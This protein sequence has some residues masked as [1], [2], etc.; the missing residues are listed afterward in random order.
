L[1]HHRQCHDHLHDTALDHDSTFEIKQL[2]PDFRERSRRRKK[3]MAA[4]L[5]RSFILPYSCLSRFGRYRALPVIY[6]RLE[7]RP[8]VGIMSESV[9]IT[10]QPL[11]RTLSTS[12][13]DQFKA[14]ED[15]SSDA[16]VLEAKV[17]E[18]L[19]IRVSGVYWTIVS[20]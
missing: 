7:P 18:K 15:V 5:K 17:V 4:L 12:T 11:P 20:S 10:M 16:P 19:T 1:P 14:K 3:N 8:N 9:T 13:V 2:N 6:A